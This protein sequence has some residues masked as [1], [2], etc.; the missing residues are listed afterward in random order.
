MKLS[1]CQCPV[2]RNFWMVSIDGDG[3]GTRLTPSKCCGSWRE[4]RSWKM[5]GKE[6]RRMANEIECAAE[7][8]DK[9][10]R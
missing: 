9:D 2:H 1:I 5:T 8:A 3:S 6:L 10:Q 7:E 4:V